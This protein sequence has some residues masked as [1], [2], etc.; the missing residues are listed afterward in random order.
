MEALAVVKKRKKLVEDE[1]DEHSEDTV[2]DGSDDVIIKALQKVMQDKLKSRNNGTTLFDTLLKQ[3]ASMVGKLANSSSSSF[4]T[5]LYLLLTPLASLPE[6]CMVRSS[7]SPICP[8]VTRIFFVGDNKQVRNDARTSDDAAEKKNR[9]YC[10][11]FSEDGTAEMFNVSF[12]AF[13]NGR[14]WW[15]DKEV[16]GSKVGLIFR[17]MSSK[18]RVNPL[19][20]VRTGSSSSQQAGVSSAVA[21]AKNS[22]SVVALAPPLPLPPVEKSTKK[23]GGQR[24]QHA[25]SIRGGIATTHD[26]CGFYCSVI[27]DEKKERPRFRQLRGV[28]SLVLVWPA[29]A[30]PKAKVEE[31]E[32]GEREEEEPVKKSARSSETSSSM[33]ESSK[34]MLGGADVVRSMKDAPEG[35]YAKKR[36]RVAPEDPITLLVAAAGKVGGWDR[37]GGSPL[38]PE[39]KTRINSKR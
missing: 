2:S 23:G 18:T 34:A 38:P 25:G 1:T 24:S 19:S 4:R 13:S 3:S 5:I 35:W 7:A 39:D 6:S 11:R 26:Y 33:R 17:Q 15:S 36:R 9:R 29:I 21:A 22:T 28:P 16:A 20:K 31:E 32:G 30:G 27:L 14:I 12:Q 10:K 8:S 37:D